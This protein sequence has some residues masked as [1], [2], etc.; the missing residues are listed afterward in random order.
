MARKKRKP[1]RKRKPPW[2]EAHVRR[3]FWRAGFGATAAEAKH[4]AGRGRKATL[5]WL[6]GGDGPAELKGAGPSADGKPLDPTNVPGHGV[7]WWIDRM[8]RTTR[9][10]EE[11][12]TLL[13]HDHFATRDVE[14]PLMMRQNETLRRRALGSFDELLNDITL[15]PAMQVFLS[16][17]GSNKRAPNEN[18]ARELMELFT[19]GTGYTEDDVREA[20]RALTGFV[21]VYENNRMTGVRFD[22]SR[23]DPGPKTIFGKTGTW[24]W[25]DVLRLCLAHPNHPGFLVTK[26]WDF[27]IPTPIPGP[28]R[29]KLAAAYTRSGRKIAP[30]VRSILGDARLYAD[31]DRPS[32]VKWPVVFL[33]GQ[34]RFAGAA[35]TNAGW[36]FYLAGMGQSLFFPPS[37]AG[38]DWNEGWLSSNAVRARF[39][40]AGQMIEKNGALDVKEGSVEPG[41]SAAEHLGRAIAA[42]GVPHVSRSTRLVLERMLAGTLA[43]PDAT[44]REEDVRRRH[45]EYVQRAVRHLLVSGPENQVC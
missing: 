33:A 45:A 22:E 5:S 12:M 14:R 30:L 2:T 37:V 44:H 32:Q 18:F 39:V 43:A 21:G 19:I 24:K 25:D 9:P 23:W 29:K 7:L 8:V 1:R 11:K 34:L 3:V 31:L 4:W 36:P 35:V 10:L 41:L 17:A 42:V 27:F 38:W 26:V 20:A 15:D 16:L 13:W 6:V 40:A 28:T